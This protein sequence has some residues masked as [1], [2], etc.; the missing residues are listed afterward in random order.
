MCLDRSRIVAAVLIF[1]QLVWLAIAVIDG[2][3]VQGERQLSGQCNRTSNGMIPYMVIAECVQ[4]FFISCCFIYA[5]WKSSGLPAARSRISLL[6]FSM[7]HTDEKLGNLSELSTNNDDDVRRGWWDYV[8][9]S[10]KPPLPSQGPSSPCNS[11]LF[12]ALRRTIGHL[13]RNHDDDDLK[14]AAA[15]KS[16]LHSVSPLP[17]L[18]SVRLSENPASPTSGR[19]ETAG[20]RSPVPSFSSHLVGLR[21]RMVLLREV[22]RD[23]LCYTTFITSLCVVVTVVAVAGLNTRMLSVSGWLTL[24][25]TVISVLAVHSFGR[26]IHRHEIEAMMQHPWSWDPS[27]QTDRRALEPPRRPRS[28]S[29]WSPKIS[30][31]SRRARRNGHLDRDD[32][33]EGNIRLYPRSKGD[34]SMSISRSSLPSPES[35]LC[36]SSLSVHHAPGITSSPTTEEFH[37][38]YAGFN[39]SINTNPRPQ[40]TVFK[41]ADLPLHDDH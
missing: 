34:E 7:D 5:V 31:T 39:S 15:R 3:E 35:S 21:P 30:I 11:G 17:Q 24:N 19:G 26:V 25:W 6:L 16:S 28:S 18:S 9:G 22:M 10:E 12:F 8:P 20:A 13:W 2:F 41:P 36:G 33:S 38:S 40:Q 32:I 29:P 4:S 23:E 1:I 27:F 37:I 14:I